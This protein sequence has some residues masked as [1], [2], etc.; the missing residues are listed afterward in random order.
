MT[1]VVSDTPM[2]AII[3]LRKVLAIEPKNEQAQF[4]LGLLA[5]QSGQF[6]KAI[7]R[8]KK[9]S[10][11]NSKNWKAKYF[12]AISYLETGKNTDAKLLFSDIAANANDIFLI[13]EAKNNLKNLN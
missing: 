5:I 11:E 1:Y 12:L 13:E 2:Q 4:N 8:F 3:E 9:L 7:G 6:D 10:D